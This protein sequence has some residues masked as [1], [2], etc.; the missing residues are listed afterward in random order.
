[1]LNNYGVM[2][3]LFQS[4]I[5]YDFRQSLKQKQCRYRIKSMFS[6]EEPPKIMICNWLKAVFKCPLIGV[7]VSNALLK[8]IF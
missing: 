8:I 3:K 4:H 7:K 5:F 6:I 1:M 2:L